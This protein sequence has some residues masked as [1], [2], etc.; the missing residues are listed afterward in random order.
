M[1][2]KAVDITLTLIGT[3]LPWPYLLTA[4][5]TS[6]LRCIIKLGT[7]GSIHGF[8][9]DTSHF[10]GM[11]DDAV[12]YVMVRCLTFCGIARKRST[13]SIG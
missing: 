7:M 12:S 6:A 4:C 8:D 10:N 3:V 9:I 11:P 1:D 5:W 2:G 13:A